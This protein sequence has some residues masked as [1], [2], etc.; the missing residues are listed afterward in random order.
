MTYSATAAGGWMRGGRPAGLPDLPFSQRPP[1]GWGGSSACPDGGESN[2]AE[3]AA[4]SGSV[5]ATSRC[6][7]AISPSVSTS[8]N[9]TC[10]LL[11]IFFDPDRPFGP[12]NNRKLT[13]EYQ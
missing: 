1:W 4:S 13:G 3:S 9:P 7:T 8:I 11:L 6:S 10:L 5:V 12:C 2:S